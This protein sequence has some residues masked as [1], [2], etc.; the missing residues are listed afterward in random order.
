MNNKNSRSPEERKIREIASPRFVRGL[1]LSKSPTRKVS[2]RGVSRGST[3]QSQRFSAL[4]S[5]NVRVKK[6][7]GREHV[8]NSSRQHALKTTTNSNFLPDLNDAD[9]SDIGTPMSMVGSSSPKKLSMQ[10]K[11]RNKNNGLAL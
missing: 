1:S 3:D 8:R 5:P 7:M 2:S 6:N 4:Q 9:R 11:I 10:T